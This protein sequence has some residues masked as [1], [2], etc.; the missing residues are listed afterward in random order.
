VKRIASL[1]INNILWLNSFLIANYLNGL[2]IGIW[3]IRSFS[4]NEI[5]MYAYANSATEI[6]ASLAGL[7]IADPLMKELTSSKGN[8]ENTITRASIIYFVTSAALY[9][10]LLIFAADRL[11]PELKVLLIVIG[12]RVTLK[13]SDI[14]K[15]WYFF[16]TKSKE[17]VRAQMTAL[18][19]SA[20]TKAIAITT[21]MN[22]IAI[23]IADL[24][25]IATL[26]FSLE[27]KTGLIRKAMN[28]N[29]SEK[30][31]KKTLRLAK[32][33]MPL[34]L[35]SILITL[36]LQIDT[37]LV[38]QYLGLTSVGLYLSASKIP[39]IIP[40]L[41]YSVEKTLL[42][43]NLNK[44]SKGENEKD[45]L[46]KT[47]SPLIYASLIMTLFIYFFSGTIIDLFFGTPYKDS[48]STMA[49]LAFTILISSATSMQAQY[50]LFNNKNKAVF[51]RN[52]LTFILNLTLDTIFIKSFGMIGAAIG[53]LISLLVG[54]LIYAIID[55]KFSDILIDSVV[56]PDFSYL[57]IL[58]SRIFT[59]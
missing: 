14:Y 25:G 48:A 38:K 13:F 54:L 12:L 33:G 21:N 15:T 27:L 11:Q 58:Y 36:N 43:I 7:G 26:V 41:L 46:K 23:G 56:K 42:P 50:C 55:K 20:S 17:F 4:P 5:G 34:M 2:I 47:Y 35:S 40:G 9:L 39:M 3:I 57:S 28:A 49:V 1:A 31:N 18:L 59:R 16:N 44:I 45:I 32:Q 19:I 51:N 22:I 6:F 29:F 24:A 30:F 10:C 53:T 37:L 52:L 8:K